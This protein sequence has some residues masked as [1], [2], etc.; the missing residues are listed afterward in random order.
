MIEIAVPHSFS[1]TYHY[2]ITALLEALDISLPFKIK[3][4]QAEVSDICSCL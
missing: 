3:Q 1:S 2:I 4:G